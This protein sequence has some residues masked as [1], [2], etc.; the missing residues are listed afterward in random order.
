MAMSA[1]KAHSKALS[2]AEEFAASAEGREIIMRYEVT[3]ALQ[4]WQF[5]DMTEYANYSTLNDPDGGHGAR[6]YALGGGPDNDRLEVDPTGSV[7]KRSRMNY[8]IGKEV[9][10]DQVPV[11]YRL[12]L[13]KKWVDFYE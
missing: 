1:E 13:M 6:V 2:T 9:R 4:G 11:Y 10:A 5:Y 12:W 7:L 8:Q 3:L